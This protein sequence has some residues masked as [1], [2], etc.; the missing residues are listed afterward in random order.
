MLKKCIWVALPVLVASC[1]EPD[2]PS[3]LFPAHDAKKQ[4]E[5]ASAQLSTE[6]LS[7]TDL[8]RVC[9]AGAAFRVGRSVVGIVATVTDK[10]QVQ[11][12]YS[13][14]DGK[15]FRY[16]C[17]VEGNELRYRMIDE[18]GPGTGPG[19]WSGRG[20]RT[21]FKLHTDKV[22][23]HDDFFDGSTDSDEIAI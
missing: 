20:S 3:D 1:G 15:H 13:R 8:L 10:Q 18:A 23:L 4:L 9:K 12:S 7:D 6:E 14:D 21:T 5:A 17:R 11:L 2:Q 19:S 16:D 22:E